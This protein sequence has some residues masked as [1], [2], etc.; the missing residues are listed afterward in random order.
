MRWD[1]R[2]V[3]DKFSEDGTKKNCVKCGR[4]KTFDQFRLTAYRECGL[5]LRCRKCLSIKGRAG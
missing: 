3:M 1:G 2:R 4:F 5:E